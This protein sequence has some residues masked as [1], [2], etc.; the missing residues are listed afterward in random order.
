MSSG[1]EDWPA[2]ARIPTQGTAALYGDQDDVEEGVCKAPDPED[3]AAGATIG[4]ILHCAAWQSR[5]YGAMALPEGVEHV[6]EGPLC[7]TFITRVV[8]ECEEEAGVI[9]EW[10]RRRQRKRRLM[11]HEAALLAERGET[12]PLD[13]WAW[14]RFWEYLGPLFGGTQSAQTCVAYWIGYTF[15]WGSILFIV[16]AAGSVSSYVLADATRTQLASNLPYLVGSLF[17]DVGC[18]GL[19]IEAENEDQHHE[20]H[21]WHHRRFELCQKLVLT[22]A[23]TAARER[24]RDESVKVDAQEQVSDD[25][26]ADDSTA[27][28]LKEHDASPPHY[29]RVPRPWPN[30]LLTRP[31]MLGAVIFMLGALGFTAGVIGSICETAGVVLTET[32]SEWWIN[33][34]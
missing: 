9:V 22:R 17:F 15:F 1:A 30:V 4:S 33:F 23:A 14:F 21:Q 11:K 20:A 16:G 24:L 12:P 29:R 5:L 7:G 25:S 26:S 13:L 32:Q 10:E 2:D 3:G 19:L 8:E 27:R 31:A 6:C 18:L 34:S 28:L